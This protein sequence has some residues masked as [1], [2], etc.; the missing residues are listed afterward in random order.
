V[1]TTA[2]RIQD[3]ERREVIKGYSAILDAEKTGY[4]LAA[5][6]EIII[7]EG[8]LHELKEEIAKKPKVYG[9]YDVTGKSDVMAVAGFKSKEEPSD[10]VKSLLLSEFV[11]RTLTHAVLGTAKESFSFKHLG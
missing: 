5:I 11:D 10:L 6:T 1:G 2:N 8:K 7:S 4:S 9:A 3:L